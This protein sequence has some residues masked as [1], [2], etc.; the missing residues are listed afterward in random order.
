MVRHVNSL[1]ACAAAVL[2]P[3]TAV[4]DG[5]A[6]M[7]FQYS[8]EFVCGT[9]A[10]DYSSVVPGDYTMVANVHNANTVP[11]QARSKVSLT[12]PGPGMSDPWMT[13]FAPQESKQLNC[14]DIYSR[15]AFAQPI[16]AAPLLEGFLLIQS[17]KPLVVVARY[18]ATGLTGDVALDVERVKGR[19]ITHPGEGPDDDKVEICHIPPGNPGN[20]HEIEVDLSAVPAH[21]DH[22]DTIGEC[23]DDHEHHPKKKKK[24]KNRH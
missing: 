1:L 5:D 3:L 10:G 16:S 4:A 19:L 6:E 24:H 12:H 15:F 8:V 2:I 23:T 11:N 17:R 9:N 7:V 14:E 20:A 18:T 22:G 13:E 21:L